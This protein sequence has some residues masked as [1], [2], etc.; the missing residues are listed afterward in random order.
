M[1]SEH[2]LHHDFVK[3][4]RNKIV[5]QT[6]VECFIITYK[7]IQFALKNTLDEYDEE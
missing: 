2:K 5:F 3:C 4:L 7:L 6:S 1:K